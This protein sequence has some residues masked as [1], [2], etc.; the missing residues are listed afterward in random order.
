MYQTIIYKVEKRSAH[1]TLNRPEKRNA[2]NGQMVEELTEAFRQA[3]KDEEVKIITLDAKGQ[4][5]S[6]GADLA[7]LQKL[8]QNTYKENLADSRALMQLL[9]SIYL[10]PKLVVAI[11]EGH[12]IAGGCGLATVCDYSFAVPSAKL[13]YS[14][15]Q[16]GF[17]PAIVMYF[18]LRKINQGYARDLLLSARLTDA[19]K[20]KE[21]GLINDIFEAH[22]IRKK[23]A[24]FMQEII[25]NNSAESIKRTKRLLADIQNLALDEALSL[26]AE[27]NAA[28]RS[29]ADCQKGISAFLKKKKPAW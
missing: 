21:M 7:Y 9:K 28:M 24:D 6:A 1:I 11:I 29:T 2:L 12:A 10:H 22:E 20:A 17:I 16:I 23:V 13:G 27:Q 25:T 3:A 18:L 14:E 19:E 26:A 8:Q 5:F 4:V 15:T